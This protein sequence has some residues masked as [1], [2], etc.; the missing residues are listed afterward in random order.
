MKSIL[1]FLRQ[2]LF[3]N[4]GI[5]LVT[6]VAIVALCFLTVSVILP[7]FRSSNNKMYGSSLGQ[8]ELLRRAGKPLPV[9]VAEVREATI[10][11]KIMGEGVFSSKP[12]LVPI[13]PMALVKRVLVEEGDKVTKGQLLVELDASKAEIKYES[14]R[15]ALSTAKA[16]LERVRLGSAYVLAQERP[17]AEK[18]KL[19]SL[20]MQMDLSSEKLSKYKKAYDEG[21]ISE[22]AY[23]AVKGEHTVA[24]EALGKAKLS[25]KMAEEGVKQSL[26]IA[27]NATE[28]ARQ[29]VAHRKVEL[30]AYKV[31][32]PVDGVVDRVLV[33]GGEYNQD[34]GKPG[35]VVSSGLW[36]DAYFDQSEY[37]RV[38][39]GQSAIL[40]V[41]SRPGR[42][43]KA[44]VSMV[45]PV[46]S[47]NSGG[48]EISR[49]LRPR[50]SGSPEWAATFKVRFEVSDLGEFVTGMTGFARI[51]QEYEAMSVPRGAVT[52][53]S[54]GKGLVYV[55]HGDDE[56]ETREVGIGQ[57]SEESVEVLSG[58]KAGEN[59]MVEGHWN[60]RSDDKITVD[61]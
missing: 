61:R 14:A 16:E 25:M 11:E 54:A 13:I 17:E 1:Q 31:Y 10:S 35:F 51:E 27:Q 60:L 58:L 9:K 37:G 34:S 23:L 30:G 57:V 55:V 3:E 47:F 36:F 19:S 33:N 8:P 45:K 21:V 39:S 18:I 24:I 22:V 50:G 53:I 12:I 2:V 38:K 15:L 49:P 44:V 42:D 59:V 48:P 26:K 5:L 40:S 32:A 52:S 28:D 29:A 20:M 43:F 7:A 46:V 4:R 6:V 56:W 41:E